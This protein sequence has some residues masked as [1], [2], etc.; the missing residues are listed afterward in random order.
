MKKLVVTEEELADF[1]TE[2]RARLHLMETECRKFVE[3]KY[4]PPDVLLTEDYLSS[5]KIDQSRFTLYPE[6]K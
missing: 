4:R 3:G 1:H 5:I 6:K 2:N